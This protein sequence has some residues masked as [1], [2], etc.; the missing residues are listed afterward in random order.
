MQNKNLLIAFGILVAVF[1][2]GVG[3]VAFSG[4]KPYG[5]PETQSPTPQAEQP[6]A[7]T[8]QG[9]V[10]E[11]TVAGSE[12]K[13]TPSS[14]VVTEGERLKITFQ[15]TGK[16]PHNLTIDELRVATD[17]IAG[18]KTTTVEFTANKTGTFS[19]Y[20]SVGN[21]RALGM[22]GEVEVKK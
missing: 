10:R 11:I 9:E 15:N 14:L 2:V 8:T 19:M 17:T 1:L 21:H 7:P 6:T 20:C 16:L 5:K 22:E 13:F 3:F 18:G 12:Y 4:G